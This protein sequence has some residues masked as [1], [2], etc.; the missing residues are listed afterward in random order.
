[1]YSRIRMGEKYLSPQELK[2]EAQRKW[3]IIECFFNKKKQVNLRGQ[4]GLFGFA[5]RSRKLVLCVCRS[6]NGWK[7]N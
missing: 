1:M 7:G 5:E 2:R 6:G 4:T 3:Q